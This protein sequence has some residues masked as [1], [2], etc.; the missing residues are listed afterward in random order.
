MGRAA[1]LALVV[2]LGA[3]CGA[4]PAHAAEPYVFSVGV[5]GG[6][7]GPL[8]ADEPDP[9]ISQRSMEL[10]LG[11]VTEPRTLLTLRL[12]RIDFADADQLGAFLSPQ[13]EYATISGEYRFYKNWYDSGIFFGLGAY[14][15][16]GNARDFGGGS[17]DETA[18]G[19]TAGVTGEFEITQHFALL[20]EITGH[21]V[22][23]DENNVFAT[24]MGG[25]S[26]RF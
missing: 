1:G 26:V 12:G 24:A 17:D 5:L 16:S 9:G 2:A 23:L 4:A 10:E 15:L 6:I 3:F 11:L 13:L 20:G 21:Y 19:L 8:D 14:R 7:G 25:V 18:V 22:D